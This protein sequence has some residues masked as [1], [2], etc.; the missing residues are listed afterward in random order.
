M[1][2]ILK[3]LT[4]HRLPMN[5]GRRRPRAERGMPDI[6]APG[7]AGAAGCLQARPWAAAASEGGG[8][9]VA[10][11]TP[12]AGAGTDRPPRGGRESLTSSSTSAS[13]TGG[14]FGRDFLAG[15]G[16]LPGRRPGLAAAGRT[17]CLARAVFRGLTGTENADFRADG[18][19]GSTSAGRRE[20]LV[21]QGD[22]S[23]GCKA[24]LPF[25]SCPDRTLERRRSRRM[26]TSRLPGP[27]HAALGKAGPFRRAPPRP[28]PRGSQLLRERASEGAHGEAAQAGRGRERP[29]EAAC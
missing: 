23:L 10:G 15:C 3:S 22:S 2:T 8:P 26:D 6:A 16:F 24:L 14:A 29:G 25:L 1:D 28:A 11:R 13:S 21:E 5:S 17:P 9:P 7:G 4:S 20:H 19:Q 18:G 12:G 27:C